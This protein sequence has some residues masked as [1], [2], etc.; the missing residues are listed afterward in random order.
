MKK[1][2]KFVL[3]NN[4]FFIEHGIE[5]LSEIPSQGSIDF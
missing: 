1:I 2:N 3:Y 5:N 4:A